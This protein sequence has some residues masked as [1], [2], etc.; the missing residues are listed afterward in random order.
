[1]GGVGGGRLVVRLSGSN[2]KFDC[3]DIHKR[4]GRTNSLEA[5]DILYF[6]KFVIYK[7][8]I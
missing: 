5:Y 8:L 1:M 4:E 2:E 7:I 6:V 3:D